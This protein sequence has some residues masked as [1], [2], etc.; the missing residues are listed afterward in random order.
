MSSEKKFIDRTEELKTLEI[1]Y[2]RNESSFVI[3]YGRRRV[4]KTALISEFL[5][6]H[7]EYNIYF[8]ATQESE[9]QNLKAF[10][11][12][13]SDLIGNELLKSADT[14]WLTV[15]KLLAE[16][17]TKERKIIVFDEFQYLGHSDPAFPS[18]MQKI[19]DTVLKDA[20]V[21]LILCG[22]LVTLMQQQTLDYSS[23]LY[24][25]RTAQIKLKQIQYPYYKDFYNGKS[26]E[27][28]IPFYAITGGV[29]KYIESFRDCENMEDG[30][31]NLVLNPQ[32]YLYEEP[33]FL[34]QNEVSEIGS[35]FSLIRAI[36]MG[37]T[38]LSEI[39]AF[40]GMKQTNIPKY[41]KTLMDLDLVEREVPVTENNPEKSKSGLYRITDNYI[42][43]W[44]KFVYPYRSLLERGEKAYVMEQIR[45]MFVQ[46][47]VSFVYEDLCREKMW[48]F[49]S[50]D[51][52]DF[53]FD[54]LGRYWGP[55]CGEV[56]ILGLDT[57]G[58]NM[59]IGECKYTETEKGLPI[60]HTLQEKAA[61]LE[62]KAKCECRSFVIFSTA[63]FTKGLQEEAARNESIVLVN[64]FTPTKYGNTA[65]SGN[66]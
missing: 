1:E 16:Y 62:A 37:N 36:A 25:R 58:G 15:F 31:E 12:Q 63:G 6:K 41:L 4:G 28:L 56:D 7:K 39:S 61:A 10:R 64:I 9:E 11:N 59:L 5:S 26:E 19:W 33:Y 42:S 38:K 21:M 45:K 32:S 18:I 30:I 14:D 48:E 20:D 57:I 29:P 13:V 54:R 53:R 60:L 51:L 50:G 17:H 43:F 40:L 49:A 34:L 46:N 27:E 8:L 44:F 35:Y 66:L 22:S 2:N 55:A 47:Y 24:G 3:I 52:W 65:N 23:P